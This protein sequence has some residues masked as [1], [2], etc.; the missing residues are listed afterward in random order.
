MLILRWGVSRGGEARRFARSQSLTH[1]QYL[2]ADS[3]EGGEEGK[4][5]EEAPQVPDH[6]PPTFMLILRRGVRREGEARRPAWSQSLTHL[7]YLHA[8]SAEG[9]EEGRRGEEAPQVPELD[10]PTFMLILR[11]GVRRGGE[12]SRPARSQSLTRLTSC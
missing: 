2:H 9:G 4:R 3:A 1:L 6:D 11:R 7:Q 10:Q 12:A 8:D 5:G